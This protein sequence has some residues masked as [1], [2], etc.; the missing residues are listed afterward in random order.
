MK[1]ASTVLVALTALAWGGALAA[2]Q[3]A[4]CPHIFLHYGKPSVN[5]KTV[6]L[7]LEVSVPKT[8]ASGLNATNLPVL[9]VKLPVGFRRLKQS[10][11]P[12][13][14]KEVK[15]PL[16]FDTER[17]FEDRRWTVYARNVLT[18]TVL[19][20]KIKLQV[21]SSVGEAPLL[22]PMYR[23]TAAVITS[24]NVPPPSY[25]ADGGD[26]LPGADRHVRRVDLP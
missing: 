21:R 6:S 9:A 16:T 25:L 8:H 24:L 7:S 14:A 18:P 4:N 22:R 11:F 12:D 10:A 19:K 23:C 20:R 13:S 17:T 5:P 26:L 3:A 1:K 15:Y 2:A